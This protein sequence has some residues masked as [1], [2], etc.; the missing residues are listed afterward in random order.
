MLAGPPF[1]DDVLVKSAFDK[2]AKRT[3]GVRFAIMRDFA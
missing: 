1:C 3:Y 2:L